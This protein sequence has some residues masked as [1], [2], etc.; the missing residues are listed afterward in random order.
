VLAITWLEG[1]ANG[2]TPVIDYRVKYQTGE[3][4][5]IVEN[6]KELTFT[7]L[8]LVNAVN[9]VFTVEARNSFG[10]SAPSQ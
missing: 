9:Y 5:I 6:I 1:A 4:L 10:Y 8:S 3:T 2:G 7:A